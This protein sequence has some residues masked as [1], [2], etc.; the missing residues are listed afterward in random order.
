M[1]ISLPTTL[2]DSSGFLWDIQNDGNIL[3]GTIDA[4]DGGLILS[5][6]PSFT[7]AQ[8][9][10]NEREVVIG[11][12]AVNGVEVTR[13]IYVPQ[14]QSFAR[15]LEI[16]TNT[17]SS[18]VNYTVNLNTNLG[19]DN[20][21]V[22]VGTSSGDTIFTTDDNWLVTDDLDGEGDP[23]I[24]HVLAGEN[25]IRPDTVSLSSDNV[26]FAYN[27]TLAPGETQIVMHFAAQNPN[28][29][30]A[31]ATATQLEDL[32]LD[33]LAG[34]S[35]EELQQLVNF[36]ITPPVEFIGTADDDFLIGTN[37]ID[38]LSGLEGDDNLLGLAGS[39][40]VFGG[41]GDDLITTGSGNDT[42]SGGVGDDQISGNAG[43]DTL[44][45]DDGLDVIFGGDGNDLVS[46][47]RGKDRIVGENGND[48][49]DGEDGND[50]IDS[51]AD[52]DSVS[53]GL[54]NDRIFGGSGADSLFGNS[55][56]D[57]LNGHIGV[58][59][60]NGG[61]GNDFLFGGLENDNLN[62]EAG[63]D[64]LEGG[65]GNDAL[66]GGAGND[67]LIGISLLNSPSEF[68]ASEVDTLTGGLGSDTFVLGDATRVYYDD[69]APLTTGE[70]NYALITD[71][72][73][74]QDFIQLKGSADLY[75]L[76]FF[77]S[78]LGTINAAINYDPGVIA[79][80]EVIGIVQGVSLELSI[81]GPSFTFV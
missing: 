13:K 48:Q 62:G 57:N 19:S 18:T 67:R 27:L 46:G 36:S 12:A 21:T 47:G 33:A 8:T 4:Y 26:N 24:L 9:E 77:T 31:L 37:G 75:S 32:G 71:F 72:N 50:I 11:A 59:L 20:S 6:F 52:D 53:G 42:A 15:F 38:I 35:A 41:S 55:G 23:T 16:V 17:S 78:I 73:S 25:G 58:D 43:N 60:L 1:T 3:N 2:L 5:N 68:S 7:T 56:N 45:G 40:Q 54:G 65:A 30:T 63:R 34:I 81:T 39:D 80:S 28:Q 69:D 74:S 79:R 66:D 76:D 22:L 64:T 29:A 51:G 70:S 14:N 10:D 44:R 49:I 61:D